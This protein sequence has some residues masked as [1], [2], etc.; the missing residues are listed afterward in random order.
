MLSLA[1]KFIL[2]IF[3]YIFRPYICLHKLSINQCIYIHG[4]IYMFTIKYNYRYITYITYSQVNIY[5]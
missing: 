1:N 4:W 2:Y 5:S 3:D